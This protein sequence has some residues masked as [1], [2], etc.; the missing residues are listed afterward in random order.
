MLGID[1]VRVQSSTA[2]LD[3]GADNMQYCANIDG[4]I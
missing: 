4:L 3:M 2:K 1:K